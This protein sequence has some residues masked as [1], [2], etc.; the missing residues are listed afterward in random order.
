[1]ENFKKT[2]TIVKGVGIMKKRCKMIIAL[3]SAAMVLT[4]CVGNTS[5]SNHKKTEET[6]TQENSENKKDTSADEETKAYQAKLDMIEPA[7]YRDASGLALEEGAYI[8]IIGKAASGDFW[9]EVKKGAEQA[10]KDINEQLG[11]K[12][13][14]AVKVVFS[15]PSDKDNVDEQ[16]NILDEEL[17]RYPAALAISIADAKACEVQFD[18][19]GWNETPIVTFDS[20]S[21]YPGLSAFVS[22]DNSAS[23]TEAAEH[24]A[25]IM[26]DSGEVMLFVQDSKSQVA[27]TRENAFI[28][29]IQSA[30][31]N[32]TIVETYHMDQLD[33]YRQ[34]MIQEAATD[35]E[36]ADITEEEVVD[37]LF[38]KHPNVKGCF[39]SNSDAME[40]VLDEM[41]RKE[42][43]SPFVVGYDVNKNSLEAL[44]AGKIDG[45]IVQNPFG[46]GYAATIAS[47]RAAL[48]MGNE[49]FV[50]TGYTWVTK[51]NLNDDAIQNIL[52]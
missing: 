6:K 46:M 49:A 48:N 32:I 51:S 45:L 27:Q 36:A 18:Q 42:N 23:A 39:A 28:S 4:A 21:D 25:E 19:A 17:S 10:G 40:L 16:V 35:K 44:E 26:G 5:D 31:P 38:A 1:M 14:K 34:Q 7:A 41:E 12:G 29:Q 20:S 8:S 9:D 43:V 13:K 50:N 24:L 37:Y 52:N 47:A 22:T 2:M 33:A 3:L 11:Y 30:H 15:G